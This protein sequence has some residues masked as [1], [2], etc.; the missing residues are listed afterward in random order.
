M[1]LASRTRTGISAI[2]LLLCLQSITC[3]PTRAQL[4]VYDALGWKEWFA[5]TL[6]QIEQTK[7]QGKML[8][9]MV[10]QAQNLT[11][12]NWD[13]V[14]GIADDL[15]QQVD[16]I[17][18]YMGRYGGIDSF[19]DLFKDVDAYRLQPCL[20]LDVE[21]SADQIKE[22]LKP[23][24]ISNEARKQ[25]NDRVFR[26]IK[27]QQENMA[28]DAAQLAKMQASVSNSEGRQQTAQAAAQLAGAQANQLIQIRSLLIAQQSMQ[29]TQAQSAQV[30]EA[31]EHAAGEALRKTEYTPTGNAKA[32]W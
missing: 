4:L 20:Q 3:T 16:L 21:C 30:R 6:E 14:V 1:K 24:V 32:W 25:A 23:E 28:K 31:R 13:D 9:D 17:D 8:D 11:D 15:L 2:V 26:G 27:N 7:R 5:Q 12:F 19:L 10:K 18:S 29:T 22:M